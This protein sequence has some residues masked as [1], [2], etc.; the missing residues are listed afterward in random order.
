M[1][2]Q[3]AIRND[4][5]DALSKD[6]ADLTLTKTAKNGSTTTSIHK[7]AVLR[8]INS[9]SSDL[10]TNAGVDLGDIEVL[11][12]DDASPEP[13][14]TLDVFGKIYVVR[15]PVQP[16]NPLGTVFGYRIMAR[17]T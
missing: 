4:I 6:G 1:V 8:R 14:D 9:Q 11:L 7:G 10:R 5:R 12:G 3:T 15:S 13:G 16:I 2:D 17:P